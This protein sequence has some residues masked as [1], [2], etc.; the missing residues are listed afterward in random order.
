MLIGQ[1]SLAGLAELRDFERHRLSSYDRKGGNRDF[2]VVRSGE[3]ASLGEIEGA[4]CVKHIW[5]TLAMLP[6]LVDPLREIVLR[7]HWDKEDSP[8]VDVPIGDFFGVGFG[9]RR[10]FTSLPLDMSPEDG[11]SMNCWFPM[12]FSDGARFEVVNESASTMIFY[13]YVDYEA[14]RGPDAVA[15]LG[16]F[17]SH[18][19]QQSPTAGIA[20]AEGWTRED[21]G[22]DE[23]KTA[24]PGLALDG[25]W[26]HP[27]L[28]GDDNYVILDVAGD[29]QY[30][31]CVLNVDVQDRQV[32]DW[33]GEGDDMVFIDGE[34]WPPR[35]H[36]TGTEDYFNTAFCPTQEVSNPYHG[37]TVYSGTPEWPWGGRNSMYRFHIEDPIRFRSSIKV[38]METGHANALANHYSSVAYWYQRGR[39]EPLPALPGVSERRA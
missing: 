4:G 32:N 6:D 24:G 22:Y 36:G 10:N 15:E 12:P 39:T 23:A 34:S 31:G 2:L 29:G 3:T 30:V 5:V 37:I 18:Y 14:Y 17:H 7:A 35:L 25:P 28:S 27:N 38:T 8:S 13:F 19:R 9:M 26:K 33:Y 20:A 16:R 1:G 21:Y 11:K